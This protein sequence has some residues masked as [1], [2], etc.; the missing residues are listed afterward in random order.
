VASQGLS[1]R[2]T[3]VLVKKLCE[4]AAGGGAPAAR[5]AAADYSDL[6]DELY[7]VLEAPVRITSGARGGNI[8]IAFKSKAELE[9]IVDLLRSLGA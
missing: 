6:V 5:R 7:G 3:E 1:V 9:R 2:Q 4:E 8:Q